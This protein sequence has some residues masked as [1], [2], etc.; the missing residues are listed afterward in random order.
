MVKSPRGYAG[1]GECVYMHA[2]SVRPVG[3]ADVTVVSCGSLALLPFAQILPTA[4]LKKKK[5]KAKMRLAH[6]QTSMSS[7][8]GWGGGEGEWRGFLNF[9]AV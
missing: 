3:A 5:K 8:W 2:A 4:G 1:V 6:K 7:Q 9:D